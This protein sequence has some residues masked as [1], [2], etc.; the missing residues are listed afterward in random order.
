MLKYMQDFLMRQEDDIEEFWAMFAHADTEFSGQLSKD[1]IQ[2]QLLKK[3]IK[4]TEKELQELILQFDVVGDGVLYEKE[5]VAMM[6]SFT[7][8]I[9]YDKARIISSKLQQKR[10]LNVLDFKKALGKSWPKTGS[11]F[12]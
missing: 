2:K 1:K 6:S 4:L 11:G 12:K 8:M 3:G 5:F 9:Y 10:R 7:D